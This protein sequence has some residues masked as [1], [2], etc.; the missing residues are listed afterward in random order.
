MCKKLDE[1]AGLS[2]YEI[3]LKCNQTNSIPVDLDVILKVLGILKYPSE[4]TVLEK[5]F[6]NRKISGLVL[7][8]ED[9]IGIFYNKSDSIPQKRF[10]ISHELAHCCLH[11]ELLTDG[12][13]EFLEFDEANNV[14]EKEASIF[15]RNLLIPEQSLK[16]IYKELL[17]PSLSGLADIFQVPEKIMKQRLDELHLKYQY[18]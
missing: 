18:S 1:I 9:D 4:F 7:L 6:S 14:H 8:H 17:E 15:A 11:G 13:I 3:L 12:Y 5:D 10:T 16:K 2:E